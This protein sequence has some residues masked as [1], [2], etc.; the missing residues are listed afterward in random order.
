MLLGQQGCVGGP[1][2]ALHC[3]QCLGL[4][5]SSA[6]LEAS[7]ARHHLCPYPVPG[8]LLGSPSLPG[9]VGRANIKA[10]LGESQGL[11]LPLPRDASPW[12]FLQRLS[13]EEALEWQ[14][15]S[16][17]DLPRKKFWL[18]EM[19]GLWGAAAA[20]AAPLVPWGVL[21]E[22]ESEGQFE[23]ASCRS[24]GWSCP[25]AVPAAPAAECLDR[26]SSSLESAP[27]GD[28]ESGQWGPQEIC[29]PGSHGLDRAL[30][31][32]QHW[33]QGSKGLDWLLSSWWLCWA[34]PGRVLLCWGG[35]GGLGRQRRAKNV[36][37]PPGCSIHV[38][39]APREGIFGTGGWQWRGPTAVQ[40]GES[41]RTSLRLSMA[42]GEEGNPA[43]TQFWGG[44]CAAQ[45]PSTL[46][47]PR[48][49][50]VLVPACPWDAWCPHKPSSVA[51]GCCS[52]SFGVAESG[53]WNIQ[54]TPQLFSQQKSDPAPC[55]GTAPGWHCLGV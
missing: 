7:P 51:A 45:G 36:Q 34:H 55:C 42:G 19:R 38:L 28:E 23:A 5:S 11:C 24:Q 13:K 30:R 40:A 54:Q 18:W 15:C 12:S 29:H 46:S 22:A 49:S 41:T 4:S 10:L 48:I 50:S 6:E 2:R 35:S 20:P 33:D 14:L 16:P 37:Q 26:C 17:V 52:G 43:G 8:I 47:A 1:S 21:H 32:H 25:R 53:P 9:A 44:H 3:Q 27:S 31:T 39:G